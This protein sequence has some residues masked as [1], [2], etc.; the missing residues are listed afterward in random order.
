MRQKSLC[1][2]ESVCNLSI[3]FFLMDTS[4]CRI[5]YDGS[6]SLTVLMLF[7]CLCYRL[8]SFCA[9]LIHF[10]NNLL[11]LLSGL[12]EYL[13]IFSVRALRFGCPQNIPH[14]APNKGLMADIFSKIKRLHEKSG[15]SI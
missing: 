10:C 12:F 15:T 3:H 9:P 13:L 1:N 2:L 11:P 7:S 8:F 14:W 6:L 4:Y 5:V